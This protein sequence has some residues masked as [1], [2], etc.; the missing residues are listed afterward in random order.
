MRS[1]SE[2]LRKG[3][4]RSVRYSHPRS[5]TREATRKRGKMLSEGSFSS[6]KRKYVSN[7]VIRRNLLVRI[8]FRLGPLYEQLGIAKFLKMLSMSAS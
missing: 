3:Y 8:I 5:V 1:K 6:Q 7:P 4:S 2:T